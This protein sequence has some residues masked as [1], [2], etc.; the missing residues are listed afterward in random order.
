MVIDMIHSCCKNA[1]ASTAKSAVSSRCKVLLSLWQ[2]CFA[3]VWHCIWWIQASWSWISRGGLEY[4]DVQG[5]RVWNGYS[6]K[7]L[8][9]GRFLISGQAWRY[10]SCPLPNV[11]QLLPS[12]PTSTVAFMAAKLQLILTVQIQ[13]MVD[14]HYSSIYH[15]LSMK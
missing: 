4:A 3:P 6:K 9:S 5:K 7:S 14:W 2:P 13:R 10:S 1:V 15:Y 8:W 12:W 11:L